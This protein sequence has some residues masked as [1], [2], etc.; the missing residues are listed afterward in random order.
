MFRKIECT[1][2]RTLCRASD[3]DDD[4]SAMTTTEL[5][6]LAALLVKGSAP[7]TETADPAVDA[8]MEKDLFIISVAVVI[9]SFA[10]LVTVKPNIRADA[11]TAF[12]GFI[13]YY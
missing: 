12:I 1:V 5:G 2:N 8:E 10:V 3:D 6:L 11:N 7:S 13:S 4:P 9:V